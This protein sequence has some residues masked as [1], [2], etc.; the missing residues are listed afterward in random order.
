MPK[1]LLFVPCE[2]VLVD[3]QNTVSLISMLQEVNFQVSEAGP[4]PPAN[5]KAAM[6]WDVLTVWARTDDD[7]G[8]RYEQRFALFDPDGEPTEITTTAPIETEKATHRNIATIFGFPIGSAGRYTLKLW[9]SE[10]GQE[11]PEPIAEYVVTV[12]REV[13][14]K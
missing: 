2:K 6:K 8:K 11:R 10:N 4:S 1:L 9:L 3:Q 14:K 5:A 12:S 13:L 7:F